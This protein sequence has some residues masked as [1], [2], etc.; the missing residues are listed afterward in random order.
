MVTFLDVGQGD[1]IVIRTPTGAAMLVDCGPAWEGDDAG[2]RTILPFLR[3][4]S[5]QK[6]DALFLTHPDTDHI[7]GAPS[8]L[9][10]V[11]VKRVFAGG[12]DWNEEKCPQLYRILRERKL[13][14]TPL[15]RGKSIETGKGVKL[16]VLNPGNGKRSTDNEDSLVIRLEY[17][18]SFLLLTG[19]AGAE[20]EANM[21][22]CG[23]D[24]K[25]QIIKIAHHGSRFG[26]TERF[27]KAVHPQAAIILVGKRNRFGHPAP[28]V[29]RRLDGMHVRVF[30]T[31]RDGAITA[32]T[33]GNVWRIRTE[34][35]PP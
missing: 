34:M 17:G 14:L 6:L 20:A 27:L 22:H 9:G 10:R 11:Q 8:I 1:A 28:A 30:R 19:D 29:M 31:D 7:G 33:D 15:E 35:K 4:Q 18:N 21:L 2:R 16:R 25:A 32:E 3:S 24:L 13:N 12:D 23:E 5:I 26:S